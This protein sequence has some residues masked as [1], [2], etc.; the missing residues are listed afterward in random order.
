MCRSVSLHPN[1]DERYDMSKQETTTARSQTAAGA[2]RLGKWALVAALAAG[3]AGA[4][5]SSTAYDYAFNAGD[6]TVT[7]IIITDG[8]IGTITEANIYSASVS[9]QLGSGVTSFTATQAGEFGTGPSVFGLLGGLSA[10][11][12]G[13]YFNFQGSAKGFW[14]QQGT[15]G[16]SGVEWSG[17]NTGCPYGGYGN[18]VWLG[19]Y[20]PTAYVEQSGSQ[21]IASSQNMANMVPEPASYALV[22]AGFGLMGGI[23]RQRKSKL[24]A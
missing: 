10:A 4:Q 14:I 18:C 5:A 22:L 11:A 3:A 13:L 16:F 24:Q 12:D 23:S 20:S 1:H 19:S 8:T 9:I 21:K 7:G 17:D 6:A 15:G 2:A